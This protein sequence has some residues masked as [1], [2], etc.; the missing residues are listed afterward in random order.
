MQHA[1]LQNLHLIPNREEETAL[2]DL[3]NALCCS[4][5]D[6]IVRSFMM[7]HL[8]PFWLPADDDIST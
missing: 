2:S 3:R 4:A 8:P 5:D 1:N 7:R 6:G